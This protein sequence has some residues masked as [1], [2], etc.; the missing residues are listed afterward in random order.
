[1]A[2]QSIQG[3]MG[4]TIDKI[5]EMVDSSTIVGDPIRA[6]EGV[7]IIPVSKVTFGVASGGTDVG[8]SSSK[9]MF[10]GGTGAGVSIIPIAF[11]VIS[12]G[13]VRTVQLIEKASAM[14]N[15]VAALPELV[16]KISAM[17]KDSKKNKQKEK[18]HAAA[19][20]EKNDSTAAAAK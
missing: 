3:M 19:D 18:D 7:T 17:I 2:E 15:A 8:A 20:A 4:L 12:G 14:D 5:R 16:D 11:L 10:G 9:E 6:D 13:N 1:M